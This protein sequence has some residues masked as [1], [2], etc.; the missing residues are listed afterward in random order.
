MGSAMRV[1]VSLFWD[2]S[3]SLTAHIVTCDSEQYCF[4]YTFNIAKYL[5]LYVGAFF[6]LKIHLVTRQGAVPLPPSSNS[7]SRI[8]PTGISGCP[9]YPTALCFS[10]GRG[11]L[12]LNPSP[13]PLLGKRLCKH[14]PDFGGA[15]E[16]VGGKDAGGTLRSAPI[17][18]HQNV[19]ISLRS[20][21]NTGITGMSRMQAVH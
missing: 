16:N 4:D 3:V 13:P 15:D 18:R 14:C 12:S 10:T 21:V 20:P 7:L 6:D 11:I 1:F 17:V 2:P 8:I 19:Q 5:Q 9:L